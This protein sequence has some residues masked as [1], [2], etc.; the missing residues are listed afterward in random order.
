VA[1]RGSY[2]DDLTPM[3]REALRHVEAAGDQL[4]PLQLL[5]IADS[6]GATARGVHRGLGRLATGG[7][8]TLPDEELVPDF[9]STEAERVLISEDLQQW[10]PRVNGRRL[11]RGWTAVRLLIDEL[12]SPELT[13]FDT[14]LAKWRRLLDVIDIRR[15]VLMPEILDLAYWLNLSIAAAVKLYRRLF[16]ETADLSLL[17]EKAHT[18]IAVCHRYE[19][20]YALLG[21]SYWRYG[22][23]VVS[24]S[25]RPA[26]IVAGAMVARQPVTAFLDRLEPYRELG[27]PLPLL[28][29]AAR[30]TLAD[31]QVDR[32]DR[33]MLFD[34]DPSSGEELPVDQV[35]PLR[36]VQLAGRFGWTPLETHRRLARLAP[37]G[38]IL[39]Y[40]AD[41]CPDEIVYWQDLLLVTDYL[42][43]QEPAVSGLVSTDHLRSGA[44]VV[45]ESVE[46]V[47]ARIERY[48]SLFGVSIAEEVE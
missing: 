18:S 1:C 32:H 29:E 24:W 7:L 31:V 40:P 26:D 43:G 11:V 12:G 48:A 22:K 15:P 16:P 30:R 23:H 34:I 46:Q 47:R 39:G 38:L 36:L 19:E 21:A 8:L 41:A 25:L 5:V 37:L 13:G 2:P 28:D 35:T 17:P 14:G 6:C 45:N 10:D 44:V 33:A 9:S 42:D 3:E 4:S 20:F 27:A